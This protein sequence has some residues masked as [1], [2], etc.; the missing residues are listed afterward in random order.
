[1][2]MTLQDAKDWDATDEKFTFCLDLLDISASHPKAN[3]LVED[4]ES[5][6]QAKLDEQ[7]TQEE[8]E[9]MNRQEKA[10]EA[11]MGAISMGHSPAAAQEVYN[12]YTRHNANRDWNKKMS[13]ERYLERGE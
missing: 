7:M 11:G 6:F 3:E 1:M 10:A 2:F 12:T 4:L 5:D 9:Q 8:W 13:F